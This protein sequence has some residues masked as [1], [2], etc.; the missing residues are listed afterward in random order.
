MLNGELMMLGS[1]KYYHHKYGNKIIFKRA[2]NPKYVNF[3]NATDAG[4]QKG[5]PTFKK[6]NNK[7]LF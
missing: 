1:L 3:N 7:K 5:I 2:S 4:E 6:L